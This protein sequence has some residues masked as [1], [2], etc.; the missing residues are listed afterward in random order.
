LKKKGIKKKNYLQWCAD[1]HWDYETYLQCGTGLVSRYRL[2]KQ[3]SKVL[4]REIVI[5]VIVI[6][7]MLSA[8]IWIYKKRWVMNYKQCTT[9]LWLWSA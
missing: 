3:K 7:M 4:E 8:N 1:R 2:E 6:Q 5:G 9:I